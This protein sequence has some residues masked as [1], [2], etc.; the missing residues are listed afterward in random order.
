MLE[1]PLFGLGREIGPGDDAQRRHLFRCA[2]PDPVEAL[3]RQ[4]GDEARPLFGA[5]D[6][7][8]VG[9]V[10]VARQLGDELVVR[11]ARAG[12]QPGLAGNIGAD[13]LGNMG[14]RSDRLL[15]GGDVE[16]GLVERERFD[17]IGMLG[18]DIADLARDRLVHI[19]AR[20]DEDQIGASS[21]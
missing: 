14:G 1:Q 2:R 9:L 4:C 11:H 5:D 13:H 7:Q 17:L 10:L 20:L 19:E 21:L 18:E 16:I 3:D 12:R 8:T 15:V 6:A